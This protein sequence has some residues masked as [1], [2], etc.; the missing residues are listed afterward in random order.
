M[1][2]LDRFIT[3]E[4]SSMLKTLKGIVR[5]CKAQIKRDPRSYVDES[6]VPSIDVRLCIDHI[7]AVPRLAAFPD[8]LG[9]E[10]K[11][12]LVDYDQTHSDYCA[13][14]C[15]GLDSDAGELLESLINDIGEAQ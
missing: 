8:D 11:T 12:G 6:G 9:W 14:S 7:G 5:D 4:R 3:E 15:I 1:E 10:F 2:A 13:A